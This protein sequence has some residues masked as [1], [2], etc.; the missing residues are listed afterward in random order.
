VADG[1]I[2]SIKLKA[3]ERLPSL[4]SASANGTAAVEFS[5]M[6][7][8]IMTFRRNLEV[9]Q[10]IAATNTRFDVSFCKTVR[11]IYFS[12][13]SSSVR[14]HPINSI[15]VKIYRQTMT[16]LVRHSLF[17]FPRLHY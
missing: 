14:S 1:N 10:K 4:S 5:A 9:L 6:A 17:T 11:S 16:Q 7:A 8:K 15:P 13:L 3:G 12:F 2:R